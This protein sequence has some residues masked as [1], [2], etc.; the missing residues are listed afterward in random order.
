MDFCLSPYNH[1]QTAFIT[2]PLINMS[3]PDDLKSI[4]ED[5]ADIEIEDSPS[6]IIPSSWNSPYDHSSLMIDHL[7]Q[8]VPHN[9]TPCCSSAYTYGTHCGFQAYIKCYRHHS[10]HSY[11]PTISSTFMTQRPYHLGEEIMVVRRGTH[12]VRVEGR[13]HHTIGS[14]AKWTK[15]EW[16]SQLSRLR[17]SDWPNPQ[18]MLS[19]LD[20]AGSLMQLWWGHLSKLVW[21]S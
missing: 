19:W 21:W 10:S 7:M 13:D 17:S 8:A 1:H 4:F 12:F 18:D 9:G 6:P 15:Q 3:N 14:P 11:W 2:Q 20:Q 16:S 5:P